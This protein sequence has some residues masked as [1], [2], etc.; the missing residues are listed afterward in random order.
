MKKLFN[1]TFRKDF[2]SDF[3]VQFLNIKKWSLLQV[4]VSW[5]DFPSLEYY[6]IIQDRIN[7]ITSPYLSIAFGSNGLVSFVFWVGKFG[8]DVDILS[9]TWYWN[10]MKNI[11][12]NTCNYDD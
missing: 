6:K 4:S 3:Y 5:N 1:C 2:G 12:D 7:A 10:Y 8:F 11:E 9:R